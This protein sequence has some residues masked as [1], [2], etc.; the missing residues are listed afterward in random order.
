MKTINEDLGQTY[1]ERFGGMEPIG[2]DSDA[3]QYPSFTYE[4]DEPLD[5]PKKGKM[6]IEYEETRREESKRNGKTHYECRIDVK[7]IIS[8][9]AAKKSEK[10]EKAGDALDAIK[11]ALEAASDSDD[12]DQG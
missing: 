5:I 7:K 9:E 11:E 3:I 1:K 4:D 8:V 6:V 2:P 12:G 10:V